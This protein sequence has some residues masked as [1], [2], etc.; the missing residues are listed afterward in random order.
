MKKCWCQQNSGDVSLDWY[1]FGSP[2]GKEWLYQVSLLQVCVTDFKEGAF[3]TPV[4]V[5]SPKIAILNKAK[6]TASQGSVRDLTSKY[7]ILAVILTDQ[8]FYHIYTICFI[9]LIMFSLKIQ[10]AQEFIEIQPWLLLTFFKYF[11]FHCHIS[12]S[13]YV[14]KVWFIKY[15]AS[16]WWN[17]PPILTS[18]FRL[19]FILTQENDSSYRF[20]F[21][22]NRKNMCSSKNQ[23]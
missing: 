2:L 19:V 13:T 16:K 17:L 18:E 8:I 6:I 20:H 14:W 12:K 11:T 22:T 21:K 1:I 4:P 3:L 7:K 5:S 9:L 23:C 10:L 15:R